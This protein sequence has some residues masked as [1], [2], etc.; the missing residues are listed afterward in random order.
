MSGR[1]GAHALGTVLSLPSTVPAN[2]T[3]WRLDRGGDN[4]RT[5][6]CGWLTDDDWQELSLL[7]GEARE[8]AFSVRVLLRSALS[9]AVKESVGPGAWRFQRGVYG[10][11]LL[12]CGSPKIDF[13]ISHAGTVSCIA[14]SI[15]GRVGLDIAQ[16]T[17]PNWHNVAE[18]HLARGELRLINHVRPEL[19]ER[20]FLRAWTAKEAFA[21]LLGVGLALSA[22]ANDCSFGTGLASWDMESPSGD[23]SIS[24]AF[25]DPAASGG[26]QRASG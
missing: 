1:N 2:V 21:K 26:A 8:R 17:V 23:L 13:S 20:A 4:S 12:A 10:K 11:L 16:H 18:E 3:L 15:S 24:L 6:P 5:A 9:A 14:V 22:P 7:R 25:D 19:R